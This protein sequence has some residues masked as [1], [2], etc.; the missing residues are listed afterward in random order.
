MSCK[1]KNIKS[2]MII[3]LS[4][5]LCNNI[6]PLDRDWD[7]SGISSQSF[8]SDCDEMNNVL[9]LDQNLGVHHT[10]L[11]QCDLGHVWKGTLQ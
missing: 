2:C 4:H 9:V 6:T 1:K 8:S 3:I 11:K 5:L 10:R 7:C